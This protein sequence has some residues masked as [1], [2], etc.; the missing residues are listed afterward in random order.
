MKY[1]EQDS[2]ESTKLVG[3]KYVS[4][5]VPGITRIKKGKLFIYK[6][7]DGKVIKNR[8]TLKRIQSLAIPPAYTHVWIC[9]DE[10]GH[11]QATGRDD[12]KRKQYKYHPKWNE[13]RD[14]T[15][16]HK[17]LLFGQSLPAIRKQVKKD[18]KLPK[19]PKEKVLAT[20]VTLIEKTFIRVGNDE[21]AKNNKTYGLTTMQDRHAKVHAGI[22][23]FHFKGKSGVT[24]EVTV[25]NP[26]LAEIVKKCQDLPGQE[27]LQYIDEDKQVRDITS[28]DV[29][30]YLRNITGEDFTAKDFR[31]WHGTLLAITE[32][33]SYPQ[34]EI[35]KEIKH[36]L[37]SAIE[38]V[39]RN[40]G[41]TKAISKKCY[42]HPSVLDFYS[43]GTF[44]QHMK[45]KH[46]KNDED[47]V[48]KFLANK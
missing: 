31:T 30:D 47:M 43:N 21:Y 8:A 5:D 26:Q 39:A 45:S 28:T 41:N 27:L 36:N 24:H 15:K 46:F 1:T 6:D 3:L 44:F 13:T 32:L 14:E 10:R 2:K 12:R 16:Y 33:N 37:L 38:C 23:K 20:I 11:I 40:L 19:L 42:I 17:L 4:D 22:I 7:V 35:K 9:P 48:L 18:L 34:S 25:D 29:N